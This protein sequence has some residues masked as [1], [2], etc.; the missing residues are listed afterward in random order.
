MKIIIIGGVAGG[1]SAAARLRRLSEK[2]E[3]VMFE[4]GNYISFANCGLPYH[5]GGVIKERDN[6]LVQT[7][8]DMEARFN[9]DIRVRS[10]VVYIDRKKKSITVRNLDDGEEYSESYDKLLLSPGAEP[11]RP[12]I[13]GIGSERIKTL[14]NIADMDR[15]NEY[16]QNNNILNAVVVGAGFIGIEIA[17]NLKERHIGVTI[18]EKL[19]QVLAPVDYELAAQVHQHLADYNV[20]LYLENG[21][22][23]FKDKKDHISLVLEDGTTLRAGIVILAIGVKPETSL[24]KEAGLELGKTG[25]IKI[26]QYM[27]TSDPS[28]Y[29]VGDAVEVSHVINSTEVLIPLAWPAN[30]QGRIVA[31]NIAGKRKKAYN[32][33]LGTSILKVFDLTVAATGMNEKVLSRLGMEYEAATINRNDHAEYYPGALPLTLKLLFS[34]EGKIYGAQGIG[35]NGVDKR[36]D[37]IAVAIKAGM[38]VWDLQ[39]L[40]LAY[41]PPYNSAKD[42]VNIAGYVAENML[43]GELKSVRWNQVEDL[44]KQENTVFLDVRIE[45]EYEIGTIPGAVR[46]EVDELRSRLSELDKSK[47]YV[48]FCQVGQRGYVAYRILTEHGFTAM[49]LDGGYKL[50]YPTTLNQENEEQIEYEDPAE[51]AVNSQKQHAQGFEGDGIQEALTKKHAIQIDACGL[52]CPGPIMKTSKAMK[53]IGEGDLLT[54]SATDPAFKRD[55]RVWAEKGGHHII[56]EEQ[57]GLVSKVS[58]RKGH[59]HTPVDAGVSHAKNKQTMVIF[60]GDLDKAIASLIIANGA[61]AMGKDVSLFFTFWGLNILRKPEKIRVKKNMVERMFARMMPRGAGEL[62]LSKM[63]MGGMGTSMMKKIMKKKHIETVSELMHNFL[64]NG[65]KIMACTMTM[66][67]MGLKQEELVDGIDFGGVASYLGDVEESDSNLFI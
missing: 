11:I 59:K 49:N 5:I 27:Q 53:S 8:E 62:K 1:A 4:R 33:S 23:E 39:D 64:D 16:I 40:E 45:E 3:I 17:E 7:E 30:R 31:D 38:K 37:T 24:A 34:K 66:D 58:I 29:A 36:I 51:L 46:I 52:Q 21:V 28:I 35:Y 54:I 60:S 12:P 14:R 55:V 43:T 32:G 9:M 10:E 47:T 26:D 57:E 22:K 25:G 63:H 13:P 18:V 48:V 50:W 15:I 61:L 6:L 20:G 65:G 19:N 44:M 42:P 41:A 2:N 56:Q 67:V